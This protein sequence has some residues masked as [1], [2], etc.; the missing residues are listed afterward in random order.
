MP[1]P[2]DAVPV[3]RIAVE[4]VEGQDGTDSGG[5]SCHGL[6]IFQPFGRLADEAIRRKN[7]NEDP[8]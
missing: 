3:I 1:R 5:V 4:L 8:Q 2:K 7:Q 6:E